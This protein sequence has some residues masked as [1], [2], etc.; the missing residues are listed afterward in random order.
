MNGIQIRTGDLLY[1][2]AKRW[3]Q[4]LA[5]TIVGLVFG[6][7]LSGV[8][9]MQGKSMSYEISCSV[10]VTSQS[11][12]G[13]FTG[14]SAYLNPSD[15]YLAQD[16][17]D[18]VD[19]VLKSS[20][21]MEETISRAGV[22]DVTAEELKS[23]LSLERYNETQIIEMT[24][25]WREAAE[26]VRLMSA[27]LDEAREL[28]PE[29]LMVGSVSVINEPSA[30]YLAGGGA[31]SG[32]WGM[33]L[34]LGFLAGIGMAV[35]DLIM[36]P[37]LIN[38]K[39]VETVF[40]LETIGVIPRDDGY[41]RQKAA[42]LV[43]DGYVT[44]AVEQNFSSSA[45]ILRNLLGSREKQHCFYVT[46]TENGEGKSTV[47]A[48]LA[49][50]L[51]D[52]E[53]KVLLIDLDTK[54]PS[55][56]GLFLDAVDYSRS[57]NALYKGEATPQEAVITLTGYLDLL[58]AILERNAIP[59]DAALLDFIRELS[60][61]YDYVILDA[62]P[63]GQASNA[64]SLNQI[65]GTALFVI[66]YDMATMNEIERAI[67]KLDKSGARI[68]GCIVNAS[69]SIQDLHVFEG[70]KASKERGERREKKP[71]GKV[72]KGREAEMKSSSSMDRL[73]DLLAS[74]R[75]ER[76]EEAKKADEREIRP[77]SQSMMEDLTSSP[78]DQA[79]TDDDALDALLKIGTEK[80]EQEKNNGADQHDDAE[81]EKS[82]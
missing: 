21:S 46:S 4:V 33:M 70:G 9:Y 82:E 17:V 58:P 10:A 56:G 50:Q 8:S 62:P 64:L 1:A 60:A 35:L 41:F 15:F 79:M 63:V 78:A 66:R 11:G 65:A 14:N 12:T 29:T 55:L 71:A 69:Q 67:E 77:R 59:V 45:Y 81:S 32:L 27:L 30:R 52:M 37:T 20:R 44:S 54:N 6:I 49:I 72:R 47:A 73:D 25:Q 42:R 80:R 51:S 74:I 38:T 40:G 36:R 61:G 76:E 3:R 68:L 28:L 31:A 19:Y 75:T 48:N 26:G 43:K 53:K 18:A 5:L 39:D 34:G 57:L 7:A 24:L 16:M 23:Y 2:A 22:S 13:T